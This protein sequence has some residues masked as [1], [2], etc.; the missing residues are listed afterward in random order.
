MRLAHDHSVGRVGEMMW[1]GP[2][3]LRLAHDHSVGRVD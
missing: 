2:N 3:S 1:C